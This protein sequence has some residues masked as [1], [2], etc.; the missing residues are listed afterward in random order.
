M[1]KLNCKLQFPL[2]GEAYDLSAESFGS[3]VRRTNM[4]PAT[5]NRTKSPTPRATLATIV[6]P[7]FKKH[8]EYEQQYPSEEEY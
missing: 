4:A 6:N 3:D 7:H 8:A 2:M 1:T 5:P